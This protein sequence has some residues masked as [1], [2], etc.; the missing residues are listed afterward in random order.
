MRMRNITKLLM[1]F[2]LCLVGM[3]GNAQNVTLRGDNGSL[4][5]AVKNGGTG[6]T[7]FRCNGCATWQHEQLCMVLTSSDGKVLTPNG[8]LDNPANNLFKSSDGK[9]LQIAHGQ[10]V[11]NGDYTSTADD[12]PSNVC[13]LSLSLPSGYRFTSYTITFS[14]PADVYIGTT[15][16]RNGTSYGVYLNPTSYHSAS[17]GRLA[18]VPRTYQ[19]EGDGYGTGVTTFGETGRDFATY[20]TSA[21]IAPG[22]TVQTIERAENEA[23]PMGNVLYFKLDLPTHVRTMIQ[24]ESAEFYFTSEDNYA[25]LTP[26]GVISSPV[27]AVDVPFSTS[28]VDFGPIQKRNYQGIDR[29]S[30]S[31]ANV[32]DLEANFVLYE[33]ES[34]KDGTDI[35]D[36]SGKVVEYKSGSISSV[37]GYFKFDS[38]SKEQIYYIETPTYVKLSDGNKNPVGY[39]IVGVE[40]DYATNVTASRTFHITY[41]YEGVTYYLNTNGRFTTTQVTWEM[42]GQGFISSGSGSSKRYL[43]FNNGRVATQSTQPSNSERFAIDGSNNIYQT[44]W[45]TYFIRAGQVTSHEEWQG[46]YWNGQYVTII[47]YIDAL[48]NPDDYPK[49]VY[50]EISTTSSGNTGNFTFK[51]YDKQGLN[52]ETISVTGAGTKTLTGLNNDAVMFGIQGTGL[53]RATLMLQALDPYLDKM[54]VVLRDVDQP[55]VKMSQTFTASDFSVSGG[56]FYFYMPADLVSTVPTSPTKVEISFEEL[57]SKYFD[58]T[59]TGGHTANNS[60]LNFVKSQHYNV[61]GTSN[62]NVYSNTAEAASS[63]LESVR[64]AANNGA[65]QNVRTKVNIVGDSP[66]EFNNA[67]QVGNITGNASVTYR[68]YPFSLE[69][70]RNTPNNGSFYT[71]KFNVHTQSQ[72]S[73]KTGYVF[74]TDE[75]RYNIAPTTATQHRAYAYYTMIV[76][77]QPATYTPQVTFTK[78]YDYTNYDNSAVE[79]GSTDENKAFYGAVVTAVDGTGK[80]GYSSTD[81]IFA[82]INAKIQAG[83]T[84]AVPESS[85]EILYLDFSQLKGVYEITTS[86]HQSMEDY[87]ATNA[88][89]C[90]IF[91]PEGHSAPNNNVA[92]KQSSGSFMAANNIILTDKQPFYSPYN[93]Q[94]DPANYA[95][96]TRKLT[97]ADYNKDVYAMV[98]LPF[99]LTVE[100]GKHI[101]P[102]VDNQP[103]GKNSFW[104]REMKSASLVEQTRSHNYG[105]AYFDNITGAQTAANKPYMV[106]VDAATVQGEDISFEA[107]QKGAY[108]QATQG[109]SPRNGTGEHGAYS[110]QYL[111]NGESVNGTLDTPSMTVGLHSEGSYSGQKYDRYDSENIFYFANNS[112]YNLHKLMKSKRYLYAYPFHPVYVFD[113][114]ATSPVNK[115]GGLDITFEPFD[116]DGIQ[117]MSKAYV[118]DLA[119]RSGKGY[120]QV[121]TSKGQTVDI[122]SLNGTSYSKLEMNAGDS[123]TVVLPAG[124]YVVNNV[125]IIVK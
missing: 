37:G 21:S 1:L 120:I 50:E 65:G 102:S 55:Q 31:S 117:E 10:Y 18:M 11:G 103:S 66:F 47:D 63:T 82:A 85:K 43:Y 15:Q 70:Y 13:F 79:G 68:E 123:K 54:E 122:R 32:T 96:Y 38:P 26:A 46:S 98:M 29:V 49:A 41:T 105:I 76:H 34:I 19:S 71:M 88:P 83:P 60:R 111:Y 7:F 106:V 8:Q 77:V 124:V 104:V 113:G 118:P 112:F 116:L 108:I 20:K 94:V 53:V 80:P 58:E 90:L 33:K 45:P 86:T 24:I 119:V 74:T 52:P 69:K 99:A 5:P 97:Y 62:N 9:L 48:I 114:N 4:I 16:P 22:G 27:S 28:K 2:V 67:D 101:N 95:K 39:R 73:V 110:Y 56:E 36:I 121:T 17:N 6:D 61:F 35:D 109:M 72:D 84:N 12:A 64:I 23:N 92:F 40:Y 87:S 78:I 30:Y 81:A 93:I 100:D 59:Y 89:N 115:L 44:G 75:T 125:K 25:P 51:V 3:Q 42:D 57:N 91:L 107:I 14:R